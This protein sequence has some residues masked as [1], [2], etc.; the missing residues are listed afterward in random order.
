MQQANF[1][2]TILADAGLKRPASQRQ[3][4]FMEVATP[5]RIPAMDGSFLFYSTYGPAEATDLHQ[6]LKS[7]LWARLSAVKSGRAIPVN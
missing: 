1:I 6:Y 5:E 2:G 3:N 7:P 4:T